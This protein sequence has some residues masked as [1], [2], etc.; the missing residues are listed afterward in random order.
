MVVGSTMLQR[1]MTVASSVN[2]SR[3]A[4]LSSGISTMSDSLM[5]FHPEIDEPS[6][7]LPSSKKLSLTSVEGRETWCS[8]PLVSVK[9][10]SIQR[11]SLS[12][13]NSN[14]FDILLLQRDLSVVMARG[15]AGSPCRSDIRQAQFSKTTQQN[16]CH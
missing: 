3:I 2:G 10:R 6:N 15:R 9:R 16:M 11:A 1:M 4:V 7:I 13:I 8:L 5:P 14:V 12:L